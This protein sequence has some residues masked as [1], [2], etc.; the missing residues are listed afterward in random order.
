M[1]DEYEVVDNPGYHNLTVRSG[2]G[3]GGVI[4]ASWEKCPNC[5]SSNYVFVDPPDTAGGPVS[6]G[7]VC[8]DCGYAK[9]ALTGEEWFEEC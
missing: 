5:G 1:S 3:G 2:I 9:D 6:A 7:D 8:E 4:N